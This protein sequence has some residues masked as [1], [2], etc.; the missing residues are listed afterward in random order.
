[1]H[2]YFRLFV[3][4]FLLPQ[5]AFFSEVKGFNESTDGSDDVISEKGF[6]KDSGIIEPV[7]VSLSFVSLE[8]SFTVTYANINVVI[9][10][11]IYPV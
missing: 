5:N 11:N 2:L 6:D 4:R 9:P 7:V 10:T 8:L 1:M 3:F